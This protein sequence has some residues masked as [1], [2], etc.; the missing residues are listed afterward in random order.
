[1][2]GGRR[3]VATRGRHAAATVFTR[4][5]ELAALAGRFLYVLFFGVALGVLGTVQ[6]VI[7]VHKSPWFWLAL[8]LLGFTV[9][10]TVIA[11]RALLERD[12]ALAQKGGEKTIDPEWLAQS[13]NALLK[14]GPMEYPPR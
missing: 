14:G 6:Q 5:A 2:N 1:M 7:H 13:T 3:R 12:R 10:F 4:S 11:Y 8:M 9:T